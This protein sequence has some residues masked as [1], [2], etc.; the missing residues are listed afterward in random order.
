[1]TLQLRVTPSPAFAILGTDSRAVAA[2]SYVDIAVTVTDFVSTDS[3][4][5]EAA[6]GR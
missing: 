3:G 6:S 5:G 1:M 4:A 2:V